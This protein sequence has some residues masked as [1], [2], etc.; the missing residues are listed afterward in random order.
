MFSRNRQRRLLWC[1]AEANCHRLSTKGQVQDIVLKAKAAG[2]D[3]LIVDVKPLNGEVLHLSKHAP[4]LGEV[5]GRQYPKTFDLLAAMLEAGHAEGLSVHA[6]INVFSE[7]HRQWRRGP[8]YTHPEWQVVMY[9]VVRTVEIAGRP[10]IVE[11][12]DPRT[13]VD[14][15]AIYTRKMGDRLAGQDGMQYVCIKGDEVVSVSYGATSDLEIPQDGCILALPPSHHLPEVSIGDSVTWYTEEVF[16]PSAESRLPTF[17]IFVNPIGDVRDYELKIIEEL[18]SG[19]QIDGIIFD[20]MRYP[21]LYGDFSALSRSAFETWLGVPHI[22]WPEDVFAIQKQPWLPP[23]PGPYYKKWL[24]WRAWQIHD[25]ASDATSLVRSIR[26][27]AEVGVYVGSWYDS[28]YDVGV[29]WASR[30]FRAGY[31][32]MTEEYQNTGFAEMFDYICT[33]CYYPIPTRDEARRSGKP[34]GATVEA[35][36]ELS[37]KAI[38]TACPVYGSLYLLDYRD[39]PEA[40]AKS[41]SVANRLTDGVMLFDLVYLEEYD[42]WSILCDAFRTDVI[43][44]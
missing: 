20:R 26:P 24:E 16:R 17:G 23:K 32:W 41:I 1:D 15:P 13:A 25:F 40:F 6:A 22:R 36:C 8:A 30:A 44:R 18:V 14:E 7:G 11:V 2:I 12:F 43:A 42:W 19:Y 27:D 10:V 29:N 31:E 33:G 34:E 4:R 3:I 21:N 39:R 38:G 37:R 9:E 35:A 28:Y 5:G